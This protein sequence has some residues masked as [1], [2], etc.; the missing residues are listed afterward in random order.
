MQRL[1]ALTGGGLFVFSGGAVPSVATRHTDVARDAIVSALRQGNTRRAACASANVA[2]P[3]L[4]R[5][6]DKSDAFRSAVE[7]AE[8]EA[9]AAAVKV[10][11]DAM[12]KSWFAAAWWLERRRHED[13][14]KRDSDEALKQLGKQLRIVV[15]DAGNGAD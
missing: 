2:S 3:Q 9:E 6:M 1:A 12:P 15:D 14:R 11:R 5:W 13:W 7:K 4:Y 10:I 8:A